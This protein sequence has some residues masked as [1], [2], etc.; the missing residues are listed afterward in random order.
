MGALLT[1]FFFPRNDLTLIARSDSSVE[2]Q[3]DG[4]L[5]A[6]TGEVKLRRQDVVRVHAGRAQ[7]KYRK[8]L[9]ELN[10]APDSELTILE[11]GGGKQFNLHSG[12]LTAEVSPQP[13]D[14]PLVI[15]TP[16]GVATVL[17]TGFSLTARERSTWLT[18]E[19]GKV[20]LLQEEAG[21]VVD[22]GTGQFAVA[23][24]H[25]DLVVRSMDERRASIPLSITSEPVYMEGDSKWKIANGVYHQTHLSRLEPESPDLAG[26]RASPIGS[27]SYFVQTDAAIQI[28]ADFYPEEVNSETRD[29]VYDWAF[30]VRF[31]LGPNL[32][33]VVTH[34]R[35]SDSA[36]TLNLF[37]F[38]TGELDP[39]KRR[40]P[41]IGGRPEVPAYIGKVARIKVRLERLKSD[42]V[43]ICASLWDD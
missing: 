25:S 35:N 8:E 17:G 38:L 39:E 21:E 20:K 30:G 42:Q 12:E 29:P 43:R 2:V 22:V 32:Y 16:Q 40:L 23:A 34:Y 3:R 18:V 14:K 9:T 11:P 4:K 19:R 37:G 26:T 31:A 1:W 41:F 15:H 6:V 7:L 28:E 13:T 10:L 33:K 27:L 36:T 24:P 5:L